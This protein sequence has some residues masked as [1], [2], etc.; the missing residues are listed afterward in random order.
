MAGADIATLLTRLAGGPQLSP[1]EL[2][3]LGG[4]EWEAV[5]ERAAEHRLGPLLHHLWRGDPA[6][7]DPVMAGWAASHRDAALE[8][9][10]MRHQLVSLASTLASAGLPAIALK[11]AWLAWHAY[12]APALRPLRDIDLLM[13]PDDA[14]AARECLLAQG[15]VE[16]QTV[17]LP[18][19]EWLARFKHLPELVSPDGLW[20]D[21]H[22]RLWDDGS[23]L[24]PPPTF[25]FLWDRTIADPGV[26]WLRFPAQED[27]LMHL[28]V[29]AAAHRFDGGP[30]MLADI[31]GLV[32]AHPFDWTAVH[33]RAEGEGWAK[34]LA[35][36]LAATR[37]WGRGPWHGPD[38][39]RP[40]PDDLV[41]DVPALLA[42]PLAARAADI[43][44]VKRSRAGVSIGEKLRRIWQRRERYER[45]GD[46]ARWLAGEARLAVV[47]RSD[48]SVAD[49]SERM[50]RLEAWLAKP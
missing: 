36:I 41:A 50:L 9:L 12:P 27:M 35:L 8:A 29:H 39:L 28:A 3:R 1:D 14:L 26:P 44:A 18:P 38:D 23:G 43:G 4:D 25:D 47:A 34:P 49:R 7:P 11:G 13:R 21:L 42:K 15:W 30:L 24:P 32:S 6:I 16:A 10:A 2:A 33:T 40:V 20:L 22:A 37:H 45:A 5:A 48:D 46:Y 31:G 19:R 17:A